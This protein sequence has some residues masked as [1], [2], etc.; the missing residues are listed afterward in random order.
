MEHEI[1]EYL[2]F[3]EAE[4]VLED[5]QMTRAADREELG[6][7]LDQGEEKDIR[8]AQEFSSLLITSATDVLTS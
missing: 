2:G 3:S 7:S 8:V 4:K 6:Q 5:D 1:D